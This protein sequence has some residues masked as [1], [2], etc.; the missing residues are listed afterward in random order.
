VP[1][2]LGLLRSLSIVISK[3]ELVR[4][5]TEDRTASLMRL[6]AS[7]MPAFPA[8]RGSRWTTL[9]P[10]INTATNGFCTQIGNDDFAWFGTTGSK[11]HLNFMGLLR[12]GHGDYVMNDEVLPYMR[13]RALDRHVIDRLAEHPTSNSPITRLGTRTSTR[14]GSWRRKSPRPQLIATEG[15]HGLSVLG[16]C[17]ASRTARHLHRRAPRRSLPSASRSVNSTLTSRS[18]VNK[19]ELLRVL[20]R[21]ENATAHQRIGKRHPLSRHQVPTGRPRRQSRSPTVGT[22]P[23]QSPGVAP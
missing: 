13:E 3:R 7:C 14:S 21:S 19:P 22:R 1:R 11:S 8:P 10:V 5:L 9:A 2:L 17:R 20:E 23:R 12:A 15:A 18:I 4:L 6:A 16:A